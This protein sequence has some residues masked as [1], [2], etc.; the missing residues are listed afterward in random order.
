[1]CRTACVWAGERVPPLGSSQAL[2]SRGRKRQMRHA[3]HMEASLGDAVG[4]QGA[5]VPERTGRAW[6]VCPGESAVTLKSV[7]RMSF[8]DEVRTGTYRQLF[9]PEQLITGKE[10][11]ANNYARGHYTIGK[12][13]VDLVLDRIRKLVG[14]ALAR[15]PG[16]EGRPAWDVFPPR[17][18]AAPRGPPGPSFAVWLGHVPAS[19]L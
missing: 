19:D 13:I 16:R 12:E 10:D 2:P 5:A 8:A 11:A 17:L 6:P 14:R 18:L 3:D 15:L 4:L 1:M 7:A 9:H